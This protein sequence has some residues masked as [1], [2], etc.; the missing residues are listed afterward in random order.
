MAPKRGCRLTGR[1]EGQVDDISWLRVKLVRFSC[2]DLHPGNI[3]VR[4]RDGGVLSVATA[5]EAVKG[6]LQLVL[7]DFGLAEELTPT[8]RRH[9][10]SF[11]HMIAKGQF[12]FLSKTKAICY[13]KQSVALSSEI[14]TKES[15]VAMRRLD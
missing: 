9:F 14:L 1:G 12:R 15:S 4:R 2:R 7:L 5:A 8:V 13:C 3:L 11:L 10:I 6:G